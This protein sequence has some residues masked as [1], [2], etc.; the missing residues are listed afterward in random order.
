MSNII[1]GPDTGVMCWCG[2]CGYN[3]KVAPHHLE[4]FATGFISC[5][6]C[7]KAGMKSFL[8]HGSMEEMDSDCVDPDEEMLTYPATY[9]K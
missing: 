6:D 3:A 2:M 7:E 5:G 8:A 4:A 9:F 1:E